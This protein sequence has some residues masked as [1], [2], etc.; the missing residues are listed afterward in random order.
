[1]SVIKHAR[2]S[3]GT[4]QKILKS[5][6]SCW[7]LFF[8]PIYIQYKD[9]SCLTFLCFFLF[10]CCSVVVAVHARGG[11][12]KGEKRCF[13]TC[14]KLFSGS[15]RTAAAAIASLFS[16]QENCMQMW[17]SVKLPSSL[18]FGTVCSIFFFFL[19]MWLNDDARHPGWDGS[20]ATESLQ[21]EN[22]NLP[23]GCCSET[24]KCALLC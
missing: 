23:A 22:Y 9:S 14:D 2:N 4:L 16:S 24:I 3:H 13:G 21:W 11:L 12:P 8:S 10:C 1:M 5:C 17:P 19:F 20:Q 15:L 6:S 18:Q 7:E